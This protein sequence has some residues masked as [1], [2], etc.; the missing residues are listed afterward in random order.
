[1][2][3]TDTSV[4]VETQKITVVKRDGKQ[5]RW[6]DAKII[7]AIQKSIDEVNGRP[8]ANPES[9]DDLATLLKAINNE[10]FIQS[11][12]Y[13]GSKGDCRQITVDEIQ[14]VVKRKLMDY[15]LHQ[16]AEAYIVYANKRTELR[17]QRKTLDT[18]IIQEFVHLTRYS[19]WLID[20]GRRE[21]SWKETADRSRA[22][23]KGRY[24]AIAD[25]IDGAYDRVD[26][27]QI[28]P[29]MRSMQFGGEAQ[30][31][32][33]AKGYNCAFSVCNRI[34]FFSEAF[35]LLLAGTGTGYSVQYRHVE[36]LPPLT[37]IDSNKVK[38]F[39]VPDTIEG[40]A[41]A[42]H[43][44]IISYIEGYY[45]EF[46][47]HEVRPHGS[48]LKTSGGRAPGHL[49]L[50]NSLENIRKL[51][52]EAQGRQLHPVECY[53]LVC[54]AADA[55]YAGGIRE[56]A[57]ICLFS[58]D[59]GMMMHA[60]TSKNWYVTH[61]WRARSN[62]SVV[63]VR[64]EVKK[65]Q[66][67]RIFNATKQWGEPGFFFCDDPDTGANPCLTGDMKLLTE[68]GYQSLRDLWQEQGSQDYS[69]EKTIEDYG[70]QQIINSNGKVIASKVY[71]TSEAA[72]VYRV[73]FKDG[74]YIDATNN[75]KFIVLNGLLDQ[76]RKN[77]SDLVIGDI[78]PINRQSS[79]GSYHDPAYARLAGWVV[80]DG[81]ISTKNSGQ[82][83]HV[84]VYDK[85]IETVLP[86]LR[87]DLK[88]LYA[89]H[90]TSTEQNPDYNGCEQKPT[91]F[92]FIKKTIE[93]VVLGRLLKQDGLIPGNKHQ[94]PIKIWQ[95]DKLTVASFLR[96]LFSADGSIQAN[97]AKKC[98]SARLPS[99]KRTLLVEIQLLLNQFGITSSI[100]SR[101]APRKL[102]MNNGKGGT[103]IYNC[104]EM[105]ELIISGKSNV[106]LFIAEV[107]FI[108]PWKTTIATLWL[109]NHI[110]SNNSE[111]RSVNTI[112]SIEPLGIQETFCLTEPNSNEIII[113]GILI[114]QCVEIGLNPKLK[115]TPTNKREIERWAKKTNRSIPTLKVN[116]VHWGWQ[117]CNLTE[118][119][120]AT[121][122]TAEEFYDRIKAA[123]V[124]G[125][126][127]AG[128]TD[129]PYLGW[130]TEAICSREALLGVS[131]TG[132]MD[133]PD[134]AL[135]PE[136]Q[137]I[138]AQV[139]VDTNIDVAEKIGIN[140]A[141]RV[142]CIKPSGTASIVVG[143]VGSGIHPH[144]ARRYFRRIRANPSDPVYQ[145]F[146]KIN[147]HMCVPINAHKELIIFPVEVA[148]NALTRH[149]FNAIQFLD[150]VKS[151][152]ENW[153]MPGT[154]RPNSSPGVNH[155]V[156]N[157]IT[158]MPDEWDGVADF[159]WKNREYF[160]G[161]S[162]L[163]YFGD[164]EVPN[165]P[166][167]EVSTDKDE[168]IWKDLVENY[169]PI[170]WATQLVEHQDNTDVG[171]E[172]ACAG[173]SCTLAY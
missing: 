111:P 123:T 15:G 20:K 128:Y 141:A 87:N 66:F 34:K 18:S 65:E 91:G 2:S 98:I 5:Q 161:V 64:S 90:N 39:V 78:V 95:G 67:K 134:I 71:R 7:Q 62:N 107:G 173:G 148:S 38:H 50:R 63:L 40:W 70:T 133:S 144:H 80:G 172:V 131:L 60:K 47:Y 89:L 109:E 30:L 115:I 169:K 104:K 53:D 92:G 106:T 96:G 170:D 137:R 120:C 59:D 43:E 119:N 33:H 135:N 83:A 11:S 129:F 99:I 143:V 94:V 79:F 1:M 142:T 113:N 48:R 155:N 52:D 164:K 86:A 3:I 125:T 108:Q 136:I 122:K 68:H 42:L 147:P 51:L 75:H 167:E 130:V 26:Q 159:L 93:S 84:V 29:S 32:H 97:E 151:T 156:S 16:V 153:V 37:F 21:V 124:I 69:Q 44:L 76:T 139:A 8:S 126:C 19:K 46:A 100:Y 88:S 9:I 41:D 82:R 74:M 168:A 150:V 146:K 12:E 121:V 85:D 49:V 45:V 117:M 13:Q 25:L 102:A 145:L 57:T 36:Q 10:C 152:M 81:A 28:L 158:I 165:V 61:P 23:H 132:M 22:M 55:V 112:T 154:A 77:L 73:G 163:G 24:P 56:A 149:D 58:I 105:F 101:R 103:K 35:Y 14:A 4:P 6:D 27:R 140:P 157:T 17:Q 110:G 162:M 31:K 54:M 127:Q 171:G 72:E 114:G 116:E 118:T 138:A 166:R 160:T